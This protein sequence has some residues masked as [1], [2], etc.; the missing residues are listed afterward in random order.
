MSKHE[1][2]L[3]L[4][5]GGRVLWSGSDGPFRGPAE[6]RSPANPTGNCVQRWLSV[7]VE[8]DSVHSDQLDLRTLGFCLL[9]PLERKTRPDPD[10]LSSSI[11][12]ASVGLKAKERPN[13]DDC[14]SPWEGLVR[15]LL[16]GGNLADTI[17]S[18][19]I[20]LHLVGS[21]LIHNQFIG[22]L[23]SVYVEDN[24]LVHAAVLLFNLCVVNGHG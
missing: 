5:E 2:I 14:V 15:S 12:A 16:T 7:G 6:A 17:R 19:D 13:Q 9:K 8:L 1:C 23:R 3:L 21:N 10:A 24:R 4:L 20:T 22:L 11:R 18:A